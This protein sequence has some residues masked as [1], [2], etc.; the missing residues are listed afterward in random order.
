[1]YGLKQPK[2]R[3]SQALSLPAPTGGLNDLDP[4]ASMGPE[5]LIDCLNFFPD[6][7][8]LQ[9]RQGY[10]NWVTGLDIPVKTIMSFNNTDGSFLPFAATDAGLYNIDASLDSPPVAFALTEGQCEWVNY[11]TTAGQFLVFCNGQG[12]YHYNGTA[13]VTWTEVPTPAGP[14]QIKG[15]DPANFNFVLV[16]KGRLW[17]LERDSMTAWYLPI[18]SVGGEAKPFFLGGIFKRGGY[19]IA[20]AR[21]SQDTGEG[22]DDRLLFISSTGELASYSGNDPATADDWSLD[23]VFY[24]GPPLGPR[25]IADFGGDVLY[26]SRRGLVPLSNLIQGSDTAI[27]Y[28]TAL[29]R[30]ISRTLINLTGFSEPFFPV[31]VSFNPE[32]ALIAINIYDEVQARSIQLVLNFLNGAWGKFDWPVRTI[33]TVDRRVFMGTND[34][35]VL[36][37][38]PEG[39]VDDVDRDGLGGFPI[40]A[41]L[42]SSYTYLDD[43]TTNKHAKFI[44]PI[45]QTEVRPSFTTRVLPDFRIDAFTLLPYPSLSVGMPSGTF[46]TGIKRIGRVLK[47]SIAPGFQLMFW[48]ML[49]R[50]NATYLP[51]PPLG[52]VASNGF[53]KRADWYKQ[54]I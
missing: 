44:R 17:F 2:P 7:A 43:L 10:R 32:L 25:G 31:E 15:I 22:L 1:V 38:T 24:V 27:L 48:A 18:D 26:L 46:P 23:A 19:L 34:G 35:R 51:L 47:T 45:F 30:R 49:S 40:N 13:F 53:G 21:W 37:V 12:T 29:T 8:S 42:F 16:H 41:Q 5:F 33:R 54:R 50:G 20:L 11:A 28:S 52:S 9:I 39:Y 3:V 6:T 14:G 36:I 4:L